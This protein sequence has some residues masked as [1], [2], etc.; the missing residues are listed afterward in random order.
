MRIL[1]FIAALLV[2]ISSARAD[3]ARVAVATNF[4]APARALAE[5]FRRATGDEVALASGS[6]GKLAAQIL[7][8][9]PYDAF[10]AA[11]RERP[12]M[13]VEEG[14]A[15]ADSRFTYARGRLALW[16]RDPERI[17][18]EGAEALRAAGVRRVAIANPALAPYGRAAE[19]VIAALGLTQA[20][21]GKLVLGENVAQAQAMVATGNAELGFVAL[22]GLDGPDGG[23]GSRWIVPEEM[24]A[25]IRQDAVLL[26]R[27]A[28]DGAAAR[29]LEF[30]KGDEA[31][32]LIAGYGYALE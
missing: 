9:A 3:E 31:R 12:A 25:P 18:G 29:F 6:T 5:E 2:S 8:G 7:R 10:L 23:G 30:L 1:A 21:A 19:E 28:P 26:S 22:S 15:D 13:L 27:A 4:L 14:A 11:D 16:S 24:H 20:L 32:A 17:G